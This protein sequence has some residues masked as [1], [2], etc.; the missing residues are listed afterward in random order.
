MRSEPNNVMI[1]RSVD[2]A[3]TPGTFELREFDK[4][5]VAKEGIAFDTH[6]VVEPVT[7]GTESKYLKKASLMLNLPGW[8]AWEVM[9][10]EGVTGGGTDSAPSPLGYLS[11]GVACCLLTHMV[12][13][14]NR[15][16]LNIRS[17]RVEQR[18]SFHST[19]NFSPTFDPEDN[20]GR[21]KSLETNVVIDSD[22]PQEQL[23]RLV[24]LSEQ[25]CFAA[26]AFVTQVAASTQV[27][28]NG[29]AL[30]VD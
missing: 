24:R 17:V 12:E 6:V 16:K 30:S 25:A 13:A 11:I 26:N 10:D 1:K 23:Q 5:A 14:I 18:I 28:V 8:S 2:E 29:E 19:Y 7:E 4:A 3:A 21:T 27:V 15:W 20:V 22:E 9:C